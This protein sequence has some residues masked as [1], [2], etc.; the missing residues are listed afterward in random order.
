MRTGWRST[1]PSGSAGADR[2]GRRAGL[3]TGTTSWVAE[4]EGDMSGKGSLVLT[5]VIYLGVAGYLAYKKL[6]RPQSEPP[7]IR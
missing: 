7:Q 2:A 1:V 6:T 4:E 3:K 5:L